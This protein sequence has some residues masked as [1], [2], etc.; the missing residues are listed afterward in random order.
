[1]EVWQIHRADWWKTQTNNK[2]TNE[3]KKF[4]MNVK[5]KRGGIFSENMNKKIW[6]IMFPLFP[7]KNEWSNFTLQNAGET[8]K[9]L[10]SNKKKYSLDKIAIK[11]I[12]KMQKK[13]K[14]GWCVVDDEWMAQ[15]KWGWGAF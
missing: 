13:K 2:Y 10:D 4:P 14:C 15:K 6:E 8:L 5:K 9:I 1:M 3:C 12:E 7:Y 11:W